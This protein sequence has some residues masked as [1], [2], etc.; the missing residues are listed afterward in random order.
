MDFH[1]GLINNM[2]NCVRD[3]SGTPQTTKGVEEYK[4]MARFPQFGEHA[5][6]ELDK[7]W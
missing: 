1:L 7:G 5:L 3:R 6:A 4:R 2:M